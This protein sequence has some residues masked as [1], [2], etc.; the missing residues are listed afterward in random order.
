MVEIDGNGWVHIYR[1][2]AEAGWTMTSIRDAE[3]EEDIPGGVKGGYTI[4]HLIG[5]SA[6]RRYRREALRASLSLDDLLLFL[7]L[8]HLLHLLHFLHP[9]SPSPTSA[10][11]A[12]SSHRQVLDRSVAS[13]CTADPDRLRLLTLIPTIPTPPICSLITLFG[14]VTLIAGDPENGSWA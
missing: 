4:N 14:V 13:T 6:F 2:R 5:S 8:L 9:H 1:S 10:F 11:V 12:S 3:V 7:R